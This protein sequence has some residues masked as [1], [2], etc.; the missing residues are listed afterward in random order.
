MRMVTTSV[1][2]RNGLWA[3]LPVK[4]REPVP[5]DKVLPLARALHAIEVE[6]PVRRGDVIM[7]NALGTGVDVIATRDMPR[8]EA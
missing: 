6:A 5:K 3:R 2:V 1:R 7:A 8:R 4:T